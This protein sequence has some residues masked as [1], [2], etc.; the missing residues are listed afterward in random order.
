MKHTPLFSICLL[1]ALLALPPA[2]AQQVPAGKQSLYDL[3]GPNYEEV[4]AKFADDPVQLQE[5]A[6][7]HRASLQAVPFYFNA[8]QDNDYV[9][10]GEMEPNDY[11][12]TADNIN[13]VLMTPGW[14]GDGE[15]MGGLISASFTA[16]DYDVYTFTVDT[17][18]MYYFAGTHSFPGTV[19]TDD[20]EPS[21]SMRLFHESDM[22][23]TFVEDFNS[24]DGNDQ[25]RGDILGETTDHRANS[26]DFRLTG[27]VSPIDPATNA[28]LTGNFYLF[29]FNG[30]GGSS[31]S[32]INPGDETGTYHFSA[33]TVDMEPWV[34]KYEPNQ[35]FQEALTNPM[36]MLP[37]DA[38]VRTFM[39]FNPDTV[40][41]VK[42]GESYT[43]IIPD[44]GQQRVSATVGTGG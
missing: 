4:I 12:D 17:T 14:R 25:I 36:S 27:W 15:F 24:L 41:I 6:R 34:S 22:D 33:Y 16:G 37:P 44:A 21:V 19:N 11:F 31:P 20:D 40:K 35:T 8:A 7:L 5:M 1:G 2:A 3:Y 42:P 9:V 29:L 39:G 38:V 10:R 23:T 30:E 43:D 13:D 32:S 26:G 28:Q 18:K